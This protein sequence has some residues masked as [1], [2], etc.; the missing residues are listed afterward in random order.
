MDPRDTGKK[1]W[2]DS[3]KRERSW[4]PVPWDPQLW[5]G[6]GLPAAVEAIM[7]EGTVVE[8]HRA[9]HARE[10]PQYPYASQEA[11]MEASIEADRAIATGHMSYVPPDEV[12]DALSSGAVH[13]WT[14]AFQGKWRACQD[15]S[16]IYQQ[17]GD[18]S[19]VWLAGDMGCQGRHPEGEDSLCQV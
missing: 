14:M 2:A 16:G 13:P 9:L 3:S 1:V 8:L 7:T 11:Q 6:K 12:E 10:I 17:S 15:Y 5:R 18:V 4:E 19:A